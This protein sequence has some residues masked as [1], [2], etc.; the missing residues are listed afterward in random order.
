MVLI[1]TV[2]CHCLSLSLHN[3][4]LVLFSNCLFWL[5]KASTEFKEEHNVE[6]GILN[7][8]FTAKLLFTV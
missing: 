6:G 7:A 5:I 8:L 2:P 4:I 1:V 3:L